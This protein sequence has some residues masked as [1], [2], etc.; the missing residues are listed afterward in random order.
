MTRREEPTRDR[1]QWLVGSLCCAA[2]AGI[3]VL[4]ASLLVRG[5]ADPGDGRCGAAD[6]CGNCWARRDCKRAE[7][8]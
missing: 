5:G 1:R 2:V 6:D 4:S 3:S 7:R 8:K